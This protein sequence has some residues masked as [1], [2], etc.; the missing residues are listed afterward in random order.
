MF[1]AS[2]YIETEKVFDIWGVNNEKNSDL[3]R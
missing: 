2:A 1:D 3:R